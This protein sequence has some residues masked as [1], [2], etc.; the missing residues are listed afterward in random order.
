MQRMHPPLLLIVTPLLLGAA[1]LLQ[2]SH[3]FI[4]VRRLRWLLVAMLVLFA[5]ED[6][7]RAPFLETGIL[8]SRGL[9]TGVVH[10]MRL[11]DFVA[12]LA[13]LISP[14]PPTEIVGAVY[15]LLRPF[16]MRSIWVERLSLR[17]ALTLEAFQA[18]A[19]VRGSVSGMSQRLDAAL[20][21]PSEDRTVDIPVRPLTVVEVA[22]AVFFFATAVLLPL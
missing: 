14:L 13:L 6:P 7:G 1:L 21:A 8:L 18:E 4:M 19:P 2:R 12:V 5:L 22:V 15:T 17:L 16:G 3:F 10:A 9:E 11:I 20:A